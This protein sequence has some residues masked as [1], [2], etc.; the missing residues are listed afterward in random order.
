MPVSAGVYE[1]PAGVIDSQARKLNITQQQ[2][3]QINNC[4]GHC[5]LVVKGGL[6]VD[7]YGITQV[8]PVI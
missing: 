4:K 7:E 3:D 8:D 6:D 5:T 1:V 2:A